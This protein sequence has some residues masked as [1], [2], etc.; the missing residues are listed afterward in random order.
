M[1]SIGLPVSGSNGLKHENRING[2]TFSGPWRQTLPRHAKAPY[3]PRVC[4]V[5]AGATT[6]P[7]GVPRIRGRLAVLRAWYAGVPVRQAVARYLPAALGNGQS[8]RGV[9]GRIRSKLLDVART[10]HRDDLVALLSHSASEREQHAKAVAQAIETLRMAR[11]PEPQTA[12]DITQ[13]FTP[14][15]VRVLHA[16]GI[17]TLADLTVRIPRRRQWWKA[18]P[19]LGAASARSIEAFF[20][21]WP[22]LTEKARALIVASQRW[23]R[24]TVGNSQTAARGRRLR[25][26][27]PGA[28]RDLHARC[29]QR[30][31]SGADLAV[32][33]RVAGHAA[34]VPQGSRAAD[35]VGHRRARP[36]AVV[37]H[38][39]GCHRVS[40]FPAAPFASRSL[41]RPGTAPHV[42]R[43]AALQR[44][45]VRALGRARTVDSRRAVPLA[46]RTA[47]RAGQSVCG[48]Q[49]ARRTYRNGTRCLAR[50]YR[51]R[52]DADAHDR[53]RA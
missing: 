52:M 12:D 48:H 13:W 23:R 38:H 33:A 46:R 42:A 9:L 11:P 7:W 36:R 19:G 4:Y 17:R 1:S 21:A 50:L 39:R 14:R 49:G 8:A 15:S 2:R 25:R 35:P 29:R 20:A 45:P 53:R 27:V 47:L 16:H 28:A 24:R 40:G 31:R 51:R 43:M 18:V 5:V 22:G 3:Y 10:A 32:A 30:L 26:H 6:P 41:D 34:N 37:A 44:Q